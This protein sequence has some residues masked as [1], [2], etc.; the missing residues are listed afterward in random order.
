MQRHLN[1]NLRDKVLIDGVE[2]EFDGCVS[3][4]ADGD[5]DLVFV[6][7]RIGRRIT[8]TQREFDRA[9]SHGQLRFLRQNERATDVAPEVDEPC[10]EK[11]RR[12][13]LWCEAFDASPVSKTTET[14]AAFIE[15]TA[16]SMPG[17]A[18]SPGSLSRW[19]RL[20]GSTLDRRPR[21]MGDRHRRGPRKMLIDPIAQRVLADKLEDYAA[22]GVR[23]NQ[24][25]VYHAVRAE[26]IRINKDREG[27]GFAPV[28]PPSEATVHRYLVRHESKEVSERRY[29]KRVG[30]RPFTPI[31]GSMDAKHILDVVVIDHTPLDCDVVDDETFINVGRPYLTAAVDACSRAPLSA[32]LSFEPPSVYTA[33]ACLRQA[34]RPKLELADEYPQIEGEWVAFGVPDTIVVDNAW[35]FTQ[36]SFPDACADAGISIT[37]AAIA[38]P[39]YKGIGERFFETLNSMVVH[40]LPGGLPFTPQRRQELGLDASKR[41]VLTLS[42]VR[43]L[44]YQCIVEVYGKARHRA[45]GTAPENVWRKQAKV[46]GTTY[47]ADIGALDRGLTKLAPDRVLTRE[48]IQLHG[49]TY[50]APEP[51]AGLLADLVPHAPRRG[52]PRTGVRVKVKYEPHNL[53]QVLVYNRVRRTYVSLP[54]I[55]DRYAERLTEHHHKE[56]QKFAKEQDLLFQTED[57]RCLARD[58][59]QTAIRDLI[60]AGKI[61]DRRRQQRLKGEASPVD[62][63]RIT[64]VDVF[65]DGDR[66]PVETITNRQHG[67][68]PS[69]RQTR[70]TR[71]VT[72]RGAKAAGATGVTTKVVVKADPDAYGGIDFAA[73][74]EQARQEASA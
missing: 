64:E 40:R 32:I 36:S 5:D 39:Q 12:R 27:E 60:P 29:G 10:Y 57:Q 8:F 2:C 42:Q 9:Y 24:R 44:L 3:N 59:L 23:I 16:P 46:R 68:T 58:R 43:E 13:R 20:R 25:S 4:T 22:D 6:D 38:D 62:A 74:Q 66:I 14:L 28:L 26:I 35:E 15:A 54:C 49:L 71:K 7:R 19:L 34:V 41:A 67:E 52:G 1:F 18:P 48:G 47:A 51:L 72:A 11:A 45:L 63:V 50:R 17:A 31:M 53:G 65:G 30:S 73:L 37:W 56:L 55:Q 69:R 33:M 70:S 61:G 21:F